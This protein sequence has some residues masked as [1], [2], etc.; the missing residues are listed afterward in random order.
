MINTY[1]SF[2]YGHTINNSNFYFGIDEGGGEILVQLNSS[3][4]SLTDFA[5]EL[6]RALNEYTTINNNY[7][8]TINRA[9]R[10]L[11]ISADNIFSILINSSSQVST[12]AY[13]LAG[14]SGADVTGATSY[15]GDLASGS[16]YNTQHKLQKYVSFEDSQGKLGVSVNEPADG[17][18]IEKI[19]YGNKKV[20]ECEI[21]FA[22][23]YEFGKDSKIRENLTGVSDLR[24]FMLYI[25][26]GAPIEFIPD[27]TDFNT[28]T[29][30]L[31][32]KTPENSKGNDFK[33]KEDKKWR[34]TYSTG[35]INF[36]EVS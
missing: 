22:S 19:S 28:F 10:K 23:N 21:K 5:N 33:L 26:D 35:V 6:G 14:F 34:E 11:T 24:A 15:E 7:S 25:I 31:L 3:A 12:S 20:M 8:V 30:C 17:S 16:I 4:Y 13:L 36:R 29:K 18:F 27:D 9:T 2:I 32:V 1:S